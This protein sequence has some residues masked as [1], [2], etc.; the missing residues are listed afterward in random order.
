MLH[1]VRNDSKMNSPHPLQS[2]PMIEFIESEAV[3]VLFFFLLLLFFPFFFSFSDNQ[4]SP[5]IE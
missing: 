1:P 5:A 2:G 4:G 3:A